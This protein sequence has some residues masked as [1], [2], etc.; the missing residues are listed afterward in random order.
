MNLA[1]VGLLALML[2]RPFLNARHGLPV[3]SFY[4]EWEA[5]SLGTAAVLLWAFK[6]D[7]RKLQIPKVI[8][9]FIGLAVVIVI[10]YWIGR[11]SYAEQMILPVFYL[12]WAAALVIVGRNLRE[13]FELKFLCTLF[14]WALVVGGVLNSL[15]ALFQVSGI[16]VESTRW[17]SYFVDPLVASAAGRA[18]GNL[19]QANHF[20]A[21]LAISLASVGYL[22]FSK[23]MRSVVAIGAIALVLI[24]W[25]LSGSRSFWGYFLALLMLGGFMI[26]GGARSLIR[27][28][29]LGMVSVIALLVLTVYFIPGSLPEG[30]A[31][32]FSS[33]ELFSSRLF[34]LHHAW[35]MFLNAPLLG[36]GFG[37]F[38]SGMFQQALVV[39]LAETY[40]LDVNA[41]NF[42]F[43]LL[44]VTGLCGLLTVLI[45]LSSW[46]RDV[47]KEERS[48]ENWWMGGILSIV[49][50]HSMIEYPLWYAYFT[51]LA[52]LFMGM[53]GGKT[54]HFDSTGLAGLRLFFPFGKVV[55]AP[56]ILAL[57]YAGTELIL[58]ARDYARIEAAIY[59]SAGRKMDD[60]A[61]KQ[62]L[63]AVYEGGRF[64]RFIELAEPGAVVAASSGV[65]EKLE[66]SQRVMRFSPVAEAAYRHS[67]LLATAGFPDEALDNLRKAMIVYPDRLGVYR[68][69]MADLASRDPEKYQALSDMLFK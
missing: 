51:A 53:L 34:L 38:A 28:T 12:V 16:V 43:H 13:R 35:Q 18:Y 59:E 6:L 3:P 30:V 61:R 1:L 56:I 2:M 20:A 47:L 10:Q 19:G 21:Y 62:Q 26:P 46:F 54:L 33:N 4:A 64:R 24:G 8:L 40:G 15:V 49:L 67:V 41:H 14:A 5:F 36:V 23:R 63:M 68:S 25:M 44:A 50:L 31:R 37:G 27:K 11:I 39:P 52:A 17:L 55:K 9:T 7:V 65:A 66:L 45:P 60:G 57:L 42:F 29:A 69:R 48:L 22:H 58:Y 32:I